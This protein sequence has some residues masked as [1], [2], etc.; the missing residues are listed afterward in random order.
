MAREEVQGLILQN[1]HFDYF[2]GDN[3]AIQLGGSS[4]SSGSD[5]LH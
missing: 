5:G 2:G 3:P 1:I 4:P